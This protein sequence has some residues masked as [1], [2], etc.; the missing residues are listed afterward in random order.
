MTLLNV[1]FKVISKVFDNR[2]RTVL[3]KLIDH[4]QTGFMKSRRIAVNIR[5]SI[6]VIEFTKKEGIPSMIM[7]ID[8]KK[9]FDLIDYSAVFGALEYFNFGESFIRWVK[10]F[11][12]KF[13]VCNQNFGI[14]SEYFT[15]ERSVNQGCTI[16]PAIFLLTGEIMANKLRNNPAIKGIK[17]KDVEYLVS[18]FADDM[19][20]YLPYDQVVFNNVIAT[21]S[22]IETNTG[23]TVNYDKTNMYRIGSLANSNARLYS[24][25]KLQWTNEPINT[26]GI[27]LNNN[28]S[29]MS[30]N[31]DEA[32]LKLETVGQ[33]WL[34]RQMSLIG[35][36]TVVNA[37]MNSLFVY[38]MQVIPEIPEE[39]L[40]RIN[41]AIENFI[42]TGKKAKIPLKTLRLS[43]ENGGLG[44]A[45]LKAKHNSLLLNWT[46]I[47]YQDSK[48][49]NLANYYL[50][51]EVND[52][53]LWLFNLNERDMALKY[54]NCT[55][56]WKLVAIKWASY[57]FCYPRTYDEIVNQYVYNNSH[58][59]VCN[60]PIKP[61]PEIPITLK[62][63][64]IMSDACNLG[65]IEALSNKFGNKNWLHI[66]SLT[67]AIPDEWRSIIKN[68]ISNE[69]KYTPKILQLYGRKNITKII[70]KE[71]THSS[72]V[73]TNTLAK[74]I[75]LIPDLNFDLH[76]NSFRDIYTTTNVP[77]LRSFQYRLLLNKIFCNNV[78]YYW[79]IV[80]SQKCDYCEYDK[81]DVKHLLWSCVNA[82]RIWKSVQELFATGNNLV[83]N[84]ENILYNR[85]HKSKRHVINFIVL[86]V[87]FVIFRSK[88]NGHN[89]SIDEVL[90]EI[91]MY[92]R[93]EKYLAV[94]QNN[95]VKHKSKWSPVEK[96]LWSNVLR[97]KVP[98]LRPGTVL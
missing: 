38:K 62:I 5:K 68:G 21:L 26:L 16:S 78:L 10:L 46:T 33:T 12:T 69:D 17:I 37:L 2:L 7:S 42:W 14:F 13:S 85:V 64:D 11:F 96:L 1:D 58:I 9:C 88:C 47:M 31:Y 20:L 50:G 80:D 39:K 28:I 71:L 93:I 75:K 73:I 51:D 30:S 86:L 82:Q 45:D 4:D 95:I 87:K 18:Q 23:L 34:Y 79:R 8:M 61:H 40:S 48:I 27:F 67:K 70:Y 49:G 77:K 3:P 43:K 36:I 97:D 53:I 72:D 55:S 6:D 32:I 44:L 29:A 81:Q 57:N 59:R 66:A 91:Q 65:S 54:S 56:F 24:K 92:Y 35:K 25:K 19:D 22:D 89:C 90:N 15:K 60:R 83:F 98:S 63:K 94:G 74:A 52:K 76:V 41:L 84:F